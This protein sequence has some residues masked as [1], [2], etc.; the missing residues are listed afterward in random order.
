MGGGKSSQYLYRYLIAKG[1]QRL[2]GTLRRVT[3]A[4]CQ[5][6]LTEV[7]W[8]SEETLR[9]CQYSL[10][11]LHYPSS[12]GALGAAGRCCWGENSLSYPSTVDASVTLTYLS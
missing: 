2:G 3:A 7:I 1:C 4:L 8:A 5:E 6:E 10:E 12:S 9:Q 11:G